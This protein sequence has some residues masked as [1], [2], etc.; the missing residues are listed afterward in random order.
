MDVKN[1][2]LSTPRLRIFKYLIKLNEILIALSGFA[3]FVIMCMGVVA[4]Y[5]LKVDLN[6]IN[7]YLYFA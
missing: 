4:R 6:N 7:E 2:I 3:T 1:Y 5:I